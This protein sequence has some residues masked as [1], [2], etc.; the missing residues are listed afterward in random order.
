MIKTL[1]AIFSYCLL[2]FLIAP[3][4]VI[5]YMSFS[6]DAYFLLDSS[7]F[8]LQWYKQLTSDSVWLKALKN[9]LQI[10]ILSTT[11]SLMFAVPAAFWIHQN[12]SYRNLMLSLMISPMIIPP[13]IAAVSWFFYYNSI[14]FFNSMFNLILSNCIIGIPFVV[15]SV[16][17]TLNNYT[18]NNEKSSLICGANKLQTFYYITL[19]AVYPGILIGGILSFIASFDELIVALFLSTYETRTIP[20]EMWSSM[21]EN[22]SPVVL[23]VTSLLML[24]SLISMLLVEFL[25]KRK[26]D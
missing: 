12:T 4:L 1:V 26:N 25:R 10:G 8:S 19:P 11:L 2:L 20:L 3:M 17:A 7:Q 21:R 9:S 13:M 6:S 5:I 14:G 22:I 15:I 18:W 24:F 23:A 16:L